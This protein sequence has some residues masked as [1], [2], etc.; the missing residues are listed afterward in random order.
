LLVSTRID[1]LT[2][3]DAGDGGH[4][5]LGGSGIGKCS[6]LAG[7]LGPTWPTCGKEQE[8]IT[9]NVVSLLPPKAKMLPLLFSKSR[10]CSHIER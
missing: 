6:E 4:H 5:A 2:G 3:L 1:D 9:L 8:D 10:E 7:E